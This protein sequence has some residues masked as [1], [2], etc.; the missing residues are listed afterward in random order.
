[1]R[2]L[3]KSSFREIKQSFGQFIAIL[4]IIAL[5]VGFFAGLK[6]CK[7]AM[8][9]TAQTYLNETQL[10]DY[11]MVSTLGFTEENLDTFQRTGE[12]KAFEGAITHDALC[13]TE[14]QTDVV[15]RFH[16]LTQTLNTVSL[17]AGRMPENANE[18]LA[19]EALYSEDN[20]SETIHLDEN[21]TA[22]TLDNFSTTD[23]TIVGIVAS[24]LY[25]NMDRGNSEL[26][27]G[28]VKGAIFLDKSGFNSD[29]YTEV[30]VTLRYPFPLY[31]ED[32]DAY[33]AAN[34][35]IMTQNM[36]TMSADRYATIQATAQA[37]IDTAQ[38][39][40][41]KNLDDFTSSKNATQTDIANGKAQ[42]STGLRQI[43]TARTNLVTQRATLNAQ[44]DEANTALETLSDQL[45]SL[46]QQESTM[47][48]TQYTTTFTQLTTQQESLNQ[49]IAA[50]QN[51][52]D[53]VNAGFYTLDQN[54]AS[55][56]SQ[57]ETLNAQ[58]ATA[59]AEFAT[60]EADLAAAQDK[61]NQAQEDLSTLEAP[62]STLLT[63]DTN[64]GYTSFKNDVSIVD[65]I[66]NVFP[67]FF[68]LIAALVC[69]TTM[70]RMVEE[71]RSQTGI[72]KALG[73]SDASLYHK[74]IR[75][76]GLATLLGSIIGFL[77][78]S[79]WMPRLI[80]NSYDI[81]YS[82]QDPIQFFFS[83][84]LALI[85]LAVALLCG[86]GI[87]IFVCQKEFKESPA[88][89][90][91]PKAPKSGQSIFLEKIPAL[92]KHLPFLSKISL[93]NIFRY[94]QR[95]AMMIIG[96]SGCTAL[97]L[98]GFGIN[99]SIQNVL[100]FQ[101][102]EVTT[103]DYA[104]YFDDSMTAE[105][106]ITLQDTLGEKIDR[107]IALNQ[108]TLSLDEINGQETDSTYSLVGNILY[109]ET[110]DDY[111]AFIDLHDGDTPIDFPKAGEL[112][113]CKKVASDN[114]LALGDQVT[115]QDDE[116]H[117]FTLTI[118]GICD[119]YLYNNVYLNQSG[120]DFEPAMNA[121]FVTIPEGQDV[122][123]SAKTALNQSGV[124]AT[125]VNAGL[126]TQ[127]DNTMESMDY[128]VFVL[129]LCAGALSFIVSYNLTNI[130]ITERI[131]E[132]ATLKV[133]GFYP[134]ETAAY[135][136]RENFLL[137]LLSLLPGLLLGLLLHRF[138]IDTIQVD[139]L[140]FEA[141]ISPMSY[142]YAIGL[143]FLFTLIV[144][145]VMFYRI[146]KIDMTTS[147]KTME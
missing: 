4:A 136:F 140:W 20:L 39:T 18:C 73:V 60:A 33:I 26:G 32:Y 87:T 79:L 99:D 134:L 14:N 142:L 64:I 117:T 81:S 119:N 8:L 1:M 110:L 29:I 100:N 145:L 107:L 43:Q 69:M 139:L 38:A 147:L 88:M 22:E 27:D 35:S 128:I 25:L 89:L 108:S 11:K 112:V 70:S 23:Y 62:Q 122:Y 138:V 146:Q 113:V 41:Q 42:I 86:I 95:L 116:A 132:I 37:D 92:W 144:N 63:R 102:D 36:E 90:M 130:N 120:L 94:K 19:D 98:T 125:T 57:L 103:Y 101:F 3:T 137:T 30:Y 123:D 15:F 111:Q 126:R 2:Q 85:S 55:L 7:P 47:D 74:F 12:T 66:A 59:N 141:R 51:G 67:V 28:T 52:L 131:R 118:S 115:V 68:F 58:E 143:T 48:P 93:R 9:E 77:L 72:L 40:Y 127:I 10:Y 21:N 106:L 121:A 50:L 56:N 104:L 6:V 5:G 80:W 65:G 61:I 44:L 96:M 75:Y 45:S 91:R 78:G 34:E 53:E 135:V 24:P 109:D 54:E 17:V 105:N 71:H 114:N 16:S 97:L 84:P 31:S 49:N 133:L 76:A 82:F 13:T 129:I 46:T 124:V 83:W